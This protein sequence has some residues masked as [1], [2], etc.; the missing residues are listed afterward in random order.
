[1]RERDIEK[2][3][4][5]KAKQSGGVVRK[6][7]WI[8]R[9]GAPDRVLMLPKRSGFMVKQSPPTYTHRS[10]PAR[11][12]WV[13]LKAPGKDAEQHQRREHV[14]M[15]AVGQ[16]VVVIDSFEKVDTLLDIINGHTPTPFVEE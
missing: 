14:R 7:K 11:T 4:V 1:M 13:E 10:L 6:V 15:R 8:G 16:E 9:V 3:L 12:I 2:Y 5:D